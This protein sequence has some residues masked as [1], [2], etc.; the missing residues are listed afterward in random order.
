MFWEQYNNR[1]VRHGRWKAVRPAGAGKWQLY[2]LEKDRTEL[3]DL[4]D[5]HPD[6]LT[7]LTDAWDTWANT[8][9]VLP[10]A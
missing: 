8:H 3:N 2:D 7:K 4:A 9:Q 1:A 10:K 5:E 6:I